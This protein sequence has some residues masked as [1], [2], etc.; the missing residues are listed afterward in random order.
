MSNLSQFFSGGGGIKSIQR[1]TT[2]Q[3]YQP[4]TG[5]INWPS[6]ITISSVNVNKTIILVSTNTGYSVSYDGGGG[7]G[8]TMIT[9]S[10]PMVAL[11][12]STTL[13]VDGN[14][15]QGVYNT[16]GSANIQVVEFN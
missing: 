10:T 12:N 16:A 6:T 5:R 4:S 7:T 15:L 3:A 13:S 14:P 2:T 9:I 11:T 1:I 8:L